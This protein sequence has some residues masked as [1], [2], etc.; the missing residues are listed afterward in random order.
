MEKTVKENVLISACLLGLACRYDGRSVKKFDLTPYQERYNF[1]PVCPE[2][3]GGL[4]TPRTPSE[5]VKGR[6]V[7]KDGTDVTVQFQRGAE[8]ALR[9]CRMFD[10]RIAILKE[11]SPSCGSGMIYDGSFKGRLT[12][13]DGVTAE[14]LKSHGIK[15]LGESVAEALLLT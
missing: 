13:G 9:L 4:S 11:K 5:R 12:E 7:M 3:Y 14:Y 10:C 15:V 8:E 6:V 1:I 2:V